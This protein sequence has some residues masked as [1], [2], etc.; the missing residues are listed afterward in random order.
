[1]FWRFDD[2]WRDGPSGYQVRETLCYFMDFYFT[3]LPLFG[4]LILRTPSVALRG[5]PVQQPAILVGLEFPAFV[6]V[7]MLFLAVGAFRTLLMGLAILFC[8]VF[9][10]GFHGGKEFL[11]EFLKV[12]CH[13]FHLLL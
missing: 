2:G 7:G 9:G 3:W 11:L 13:C 10:G 12:R 8:F 4:G 1:M 6:M 5:L